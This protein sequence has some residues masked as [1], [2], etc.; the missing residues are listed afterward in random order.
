M[1]ILNVPD[2]LDI[3]N[4]K[5]CKM[6]LIDPKITPPKE[7]K[8][9]LIVTEANNVLVTGFVYCGYR[10]RFNGKK[11]EDDKRGLYFISLANPTRTKGVKLEV[12]K[13]ANKTNYHGIYVE[14]IEN[15]LPIKLAEGYIEVKDIPFELP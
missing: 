8:V 3:H 9:Y 14:I 10:R 11:W 12:P 5:N 15:Y 1:S 2:P 13:R 7:G 4:K 6:K